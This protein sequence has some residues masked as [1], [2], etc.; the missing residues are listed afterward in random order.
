MVH[1]SVPAQGSKEGPPDDLATEKLLAGNA[2]PVSV[3]E[4][5]RNFRGPQHVLDLTYTHPF[6]VQVIT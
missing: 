3:W 4:K 1:L 2:I 6:T 5:L